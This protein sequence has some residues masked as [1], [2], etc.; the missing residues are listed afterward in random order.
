MILILLV[1]KIKVPLVMRYKAHGGGKKGD[2]KK[3]TRV[4]TRDCD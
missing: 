1:L 2:G 3:N 4:E